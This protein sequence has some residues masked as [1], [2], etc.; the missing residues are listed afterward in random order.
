MNAVIEKITSW[1][2]D[3]RAGWEQFW[4]TPALPHTIAVIRICVGAMLFY[5]HL[6][7]SKN[8]AAFL[9]PDSWITSEAAR[10]LTAD[11]YMWSPLFHTESMALI[12]PLHIAGLIVFAMFT[13]G[14]FSR[15]TSV[16][17][18]LIAVA[19]CNRLNGAL[20]GLDQINTML[21]LYVMLAPSGAIFSVDRYIKRLRTGQWPEVEPSIAANIATRLIQIHLC[22]IYFFGGVSK[23]KGLYW[24]DGSA[25]W[26]AVA[27][28][29]YQSLN[30]TWISR[31]PFIVGLLSHA[32]LLWE[33]TYAALIWPKR[34]RPIMLAMAVAVHGGIAL[35][36]GMITFGVIMIVANFAFVSPEW[37]R[38]LSGASPPETNEPEAEP[39]ETPSHKRKKSKRR[40]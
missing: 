11:S 36:M 25:A 16:L 18:F 23:M 3:W 15:T 14:L 33:T 17:S 19:Y 22:V 9:G 30:V 21:T 8:L 32:T 6:V 1:G 35:F 39:A 29:E 28:Y 38:D 13:V 31:V 34:T 27:N 20:Y 37:I 26:A 5:T 7:W 10:E 12:W 2:D 40:K 4:F 24:W